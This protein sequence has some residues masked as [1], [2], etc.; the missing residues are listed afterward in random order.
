MWENKETPKERTATKTMY[1]GGRR[2]VF[3]CVQ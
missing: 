2:S 3:M 1:K